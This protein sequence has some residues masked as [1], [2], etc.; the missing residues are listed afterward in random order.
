MFLSISL[1][2]PFAKI[3]SMLSKNWVQQSYLILKFGGF[4]EIFFTKRLKY[5]RW[6]ASRYGNFC[7]GSCS[8]ANVHR[9]RRQTLQAHLRELRRSQP[10]QNS[11]CRESVTFPIRKFFATNVQCIK[12]GC[13]ITEIT[14]NIA[15]ISPKKATRQRTVSRI[16]LIRNKNFIN[17]NYFQNPGIATLLYLL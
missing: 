7:G 1:R 14:G 17:G 15:A 13:V 9:L 8:Q 5:S 16:A 10:L 11:R 12:R 3:I 2:N 4:C 6:K